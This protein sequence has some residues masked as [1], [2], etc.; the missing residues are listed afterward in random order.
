LKKPHCVKN[1]Q[2]DNEQKDGDNGATD[3]EI[4]SE[5]NRA[6]NG[7]FEKT[8]TYTVFVLI[9]A[10][11]VYFS[12]YFFEKNCLTKML[13]VINSHFSF[14]SPYKGL[15]GASIRKGRLLEQIRYLYV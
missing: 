7:V 13:L 14:F 3:D 6:L 15:R 12:T 10:R 11:G 5:I 2:K 4:N 9:N 8:L 1:S